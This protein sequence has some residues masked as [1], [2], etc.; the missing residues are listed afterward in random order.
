[1]LNATVSVILEP[2]SIFIMACW[3]NI[4]V[5][6]PIMDTIFPQLEISQVCTDGLY[7]KI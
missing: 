5:S 4:R 3:S 2:G 7:K 6:V 1:M